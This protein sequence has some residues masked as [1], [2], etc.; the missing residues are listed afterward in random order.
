VQFDAS[1]DLIWIGSAVTQ[2][3]VNLRASEPQLLN[4]R[5]DRIWLVIEVFQPH[6]D[7]PHIWAVD[8]FCPSARR[9][10]TKRDVRMLLPTSPLLGIA[11]ESIRQGLT[12]GSCPKTQAFCKAVV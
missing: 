11:A 12:G 6:H 3:G 7:L 1:R 4:E 8:Q 5:C 10:I 2:C 9:A